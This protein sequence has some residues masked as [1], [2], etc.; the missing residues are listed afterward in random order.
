VVTNLEFQ[1]RKSSGIS[2]SF[3]IDI[4][5]QQCAAEVRGKF[6]KVGDKSHERMWKQGCAQG[7]L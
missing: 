3:G 6:I 4:E 2:G 1:S 5:L 7:E